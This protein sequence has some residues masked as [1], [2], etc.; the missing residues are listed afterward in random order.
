MSLWKRGCIANHADYAFYIIN[1]TTL[2]NTIG[3]FVC[4]KSWLCIPV[5]L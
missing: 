4:W 5:F 2:V 3:F 1:I